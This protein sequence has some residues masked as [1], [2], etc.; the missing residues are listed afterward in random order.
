M[1]IQNSTLSFVSTP[2][3]TDYYTSTATGQSDVRNYLATTG[4]NILSGMDV[5]E[6][7]ILYEDDMLL[8]KINTSTRYYGRLQTSSFEIKNKIDNVSSS[9]NDSSFAD[10]VY[11]CIGYDDSAQEAYCFIVGQ[12]SYNGSWE[13]KTY[14]TLG[15]DAEQKLSLYNAVKHAE[16]PPTGQEI[17]VIY[18]DKVNYMSIQSYGSDKCNLRFYLNGNCIYTLSQ[19]STDAYL[20]MLVDEEQEVARTSVI[21]ESSSTYSYNQEEPTE[22][23]MQNLYKWLTANN[24]MDEFGGFVETE[25]NWEWVE[26]VSA[27]VPT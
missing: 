10:T 24:Q 27:T 6:S 2:T 20:S 14:Y 12:R 1:A 8:I 13:E 25:E 7:K 15:G 22:T 17:P 21:Y 23:E 26:E 11:W 9:R 3:S 4:D 16:I 19:I 18:T 5:N